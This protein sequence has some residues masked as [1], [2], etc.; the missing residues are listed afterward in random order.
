MGE[1]IELFTICD[2]CEEQVECCTCGSSPEDCAEY[3]DTDYGPDCEY[4]INPE[5]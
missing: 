5:R 1:V 4:E 2:E 3:D